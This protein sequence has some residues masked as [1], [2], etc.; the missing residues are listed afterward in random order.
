MA[1]RAVTASL[2]GA[3]RAQPALRTRGNTRRSARHTVRLASRRAGSPRGTPQPSPA[4]DFRRGCVSGKPNRERPVSAIG[5]PHLSSRSPRKNRRDRE[6]RVPPRERA[7]APP[8]DR[9]STERASHAFLLLPKSASRAKKPARAAAPG[10]DWQSLPGDGF[11]AERDAYDRLSKPLTP[12]DLHRA[13]AAAAAEPGFDAGSGTRSAGADDYPFSLDAHSASNNSVGGPVA[14]GVCW[15]NLQD[16]EDVPDHEPV[17]ILVFGAGTGSEGLYSLQE[18]TKE[19][20]PVDII[21]AFPAEDDAARYG[22][23]LEAEMG[24]VP[25]VESARPEDLRYTCREGG[26][27]CKVARRGVLLMPPEKTV[28]VTDWERTNALRQGQWSVDASA[29]SD[30]R[31]ANRPEGAAGSAG[32]RALAEA[33]GELTG[34][35]LLAQYQSILDGY[36]DGAGADDEL[37]ELPGDYDENVARDM[38]SRLFTEHCDVDDEEE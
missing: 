25:V 26:Y 17:Y 36:C 23:L 35:D 12:G 31:V 15:S 27:R 14:R 20:V 2:S 30:D 38:L 34:D 7:C 3:I 11:D 22:T 4:P 28:E 9:T 13:A 16:L 8:E 21:L 33:S 6:A 37:C 18:R 24:R 5:A 1:S 10:D 29:G 32:C 19:D